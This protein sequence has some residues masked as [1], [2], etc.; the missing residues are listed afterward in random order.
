LQGP[1]CSHGLMTV[2]VMTLAGKGVKLV[3]KTGNS[4]LRQIKN[5]TWHR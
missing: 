5:F 4:T 1:A 3:V 2:V